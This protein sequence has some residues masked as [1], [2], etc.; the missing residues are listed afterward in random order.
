MEQSVASNHAASCGVLP[1]C[2]NTSDTDNLL[3]CA[4]CV[5]K[6]MWT[7]SWCGSLDDVQSSC[8]KGAQ[9]IWRLD[10]WSQKTTYLNMTQWN[11]T[12]IWHF[13]DK[14]WF[15]K[16]IYKQHWLVVVLVILWPQQCN[17]TLSASL[18]V[19]LLWWEAGLCL[20]VLPRP[21]TVARSTDQTY[22]HRH[23]HRRTKAMNT[24]LFIHKHHF[25]HE[26]MSCVS[27][28]AHTIADY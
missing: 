8:V 27:S 25:I 10:C 3:L 18:P 28:T 19:G 2:M 13:M 22:R 17:S 9:Q 26:P 24:S 1:T 23:T 6:Q 7:V 4:A 15:Q 21:G 14:E 11:L 16:I 12:F 20:L 5:N